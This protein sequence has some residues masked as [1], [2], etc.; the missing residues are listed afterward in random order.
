MTPS[1]QEVITNNYVYNN[2][3]TT[4]ECTSNSQQQTYVEIPV[5]NYT[6]YHA[7]DM[8]SGDELEITQGTNQCIRV[9]LPAG[10]QGKI[11]VKYVI[12]VV[13]Y[14]AS[15][16]SMITCLSMVIWYLLQRRAGLRN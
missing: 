4:L 14:I 15:V 10:F 8:E 12:P 3:V 2:G 13:W 6:H 1:T 5:F 7:Y 11:Q 16:I 9:M